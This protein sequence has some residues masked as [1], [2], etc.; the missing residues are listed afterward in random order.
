MSTMLT[1]LDNPW[2]SEYEI[3]LVCTQKDWSLSKYT[4][5]VTAQQNTGI[6]IDSE[7]P[8]RNIGGFQPVDYNYAPGPPE[9]ILN[10][11]K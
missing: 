3:D 9:T 1:G 5:G 7:C 11:R 2:T 4:P 8:K 6:Y 10:N